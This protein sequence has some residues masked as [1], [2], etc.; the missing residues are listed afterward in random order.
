MKKKSIRIS[1]M[2]AVDSA[3]FPRVL[4]PGRKR[5]IVE[6][7]KHIVIDRIERVLFMVHGHD[8]K[9]SLPDMHEKCVR[10]LR[11]APGGELA[12]SILLKRMKMTAGDFLEIVTTLEQRGEIVSRM[13]HAPGSGRPGRF[14][15]IVRA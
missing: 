13:Q 7:V 6:W 3:E 5:T 4:A 15:R 2:A 1:Q 10:K 8:A 11:Q 12:H 14:Y 9:N